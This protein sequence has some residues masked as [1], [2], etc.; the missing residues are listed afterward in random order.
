MKDTYIMNDVYPAGDRA[1]DVALGY[2]SE[3]RFGAAIAEYDAIIEKNGKDALAY[4]RRFCS[5]VGAK[6]DAEL[7]FML[8]NATPSVYRDFEIALS[9][10]DDPSVSGYFLHT[11]IRGLS[12]HLKLSSM[13]LLFDTL[14]K[15][16][17]DD[18]I[19]L[20][21]KNV[22][23]GCERLLARRKYKE[24]TEW[25]DYV[26][27]SFDITADDRYYMMLLCARLHTADIRTK[28]FICPR[29]DS[30]SDSRKAASEYTKGELV[31]KIAKYA[32]ASGDDESAYKLCDSVVS[33]INNSPLS[34][35]GTVSTVLKGLES[36]KN[37]ALAVS[38]LIRV[39][40]AFRDNGRFA[41]ARRY[42]FSAL[43]LD[44]ACSAAHF[45][46]L[47]CKL[48]VT[49]V[50]L[51]VRR[52]KNLDFYE[53]F[54]EAVRC[55]S[56][57]EYS[58]YMQILSS[59]KG[60]SAKKDMKRYTLEASEEKS[61]DSTKKT[62]LRMLFPAIRSTLHFLVGASLVSASSFLFD[63]LLPHTPLMG[64]LS[65]APP[66]LAIVL[67]MI[68]FVKDIAPV[69]MLARLIIS[70]RGCS[71][72]FRFSSVAKEKKGY[73][74]YRIK[75]SEEVKDAIKAARVTPRRRVKSFIARTARKINRSALVRYE[76][77]FALFVSVPVSLI[78]FIGY[79]LVKQTGFYALP[80]LVGFA[81]L[82]LSHNVFNALFHGTYLNK[83]LFVKSTYGS[84]KLF[85]TSE[86]LYTLF[87]EEVGKRKW[88]T[89][90]VCGC[91]ASTAE[92]L[93]YRDYKS[94]WRRLECV[95]CKEVIEKH[96]R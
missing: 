4:F 34:V 80:A 50:Y 95:N 83:K 14:I 88:A 49:N 5:S 31:Y 28:H 17:S 62:M 63:R 81:L 39:A 65:F 96:D 44:S 42:Y 22:F 87:E 8:D 7:P 30:L 51:L 72:D 9:C 21:F 11:A 91:I 68:L 90:K 58:F 66:L 54:R 12:E 59:Q 24:C 78:F 94:G 53:E 93:D 85:K 92:S 82:L 1:H 35:S 10:A 77:C 89:C 64:I 37:S 79:I 26:S 43:S 52:R 38:F 23:E 60:R 3:G 48:K 40:G 45:G 73:I 20:L 29:S 27:K 61:Y 33:Q 86:Y 84:E 57:S 18:G 36:E 67:L 15:Y 71:A 32:S 46:L 13:K 69:S 2:Q 75:T 25:L 56:E 6:S 70:S 47:M 55:A 74:I 41:L 16:V 19:S 76:L